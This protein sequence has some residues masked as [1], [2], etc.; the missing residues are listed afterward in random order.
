M[1]WLLCCNSQQ[2]SSVS[3]GG[4][5]SLLHGACDAYHTSKQI[6]LTTVEMQVQEVT[7]N[8]VGKSRPGLHR[9]NSLIGGRL[10]DVSPGGLI[11]EDCVL[12]SLTSY[13]RILPESCPCSHNPSVV[14]LPCVRHC[15]KVHDHASAQRHVLLHWDP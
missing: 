2:Q 9:L 1:Q 6:I 4:M 10:D 3:D 14:L 12:I 13:V 7:W 11:E 5:Y 15:L 8:T